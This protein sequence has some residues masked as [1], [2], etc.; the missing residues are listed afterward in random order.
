VLVHVMGSYEHQFARRIILRLDDGSVIGDKGI[1]QRTDAT[2]CVLLEAQQALECNRL[3]P[4]DIDRL[5]KLVEAAAPPELP[6]A[7]GIGAAAA[8]HV[9]APQVCIGY[10]Q[11]C[12]SKYYPPA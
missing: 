3:G 5:K 12:S 11:R 1:L 6:L 2:G 9:A 10:H 8:K 7:N 4:Q